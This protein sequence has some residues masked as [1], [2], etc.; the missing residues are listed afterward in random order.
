MYSVILTKN[1]LCSISFLS[2]TRGVDHFKMIIRKSVFSLLIGISVCDNHLVRAIGRSM[3]LL[4]PSS[5]YKR[6]QTLLYGI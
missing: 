2:L 3:Y 4:L 1:S 6:W 5:L